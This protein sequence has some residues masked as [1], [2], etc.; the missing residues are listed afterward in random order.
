[1]SVGNAT[2]KD[3]RVASHNTQGLNSPKKRIIAFE[4]YHS[5]K[6]DIVLI[7]ETHFPI[8]YGPKFLHSHY[9][10]FYIAN[11]AN[12][13]KGVAVLFSKHS[14]FSYIS[15]H[16]DPEGRFI[17]V[18]GT[19]EGNMYSIISYYAPN[20]EQAAFF[21]SL[22][23]TLLPLVEGKVIFGGNSNIAFDQGLDK[24][25]PPKPS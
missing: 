19:I 10:S 12:K 17:L 21:Q 11:A 9:P 22:L 6:I 25:K 18:K 24:S 14:K 5:L 2:H 13:T 4:N 7:Q 3:L 23:K 15:D 20:K 1:M 16:K 8:R